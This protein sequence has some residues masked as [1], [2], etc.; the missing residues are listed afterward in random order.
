[1]LQDFAKQLRVGETVTCTGFAEGD[2]SLAKSRASIVASF[3]QSRVRVSVVKR[4]N[5]SVNAA[6]AK[7]LVT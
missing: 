6:V 5:I 7:V 1:L 3:I 2:S 4:T